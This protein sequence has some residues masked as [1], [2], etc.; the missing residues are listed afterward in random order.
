MLET[1]YVP[2]VLT[3]RSCR[4][5]RDADLRAL[6][7]GG[8]GDVPLVQ[9]RWRCQHCGSRLIGMVVSGYQPAS[10]YWRRD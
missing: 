6:V 9:L 3:C 1:R 10:G 8:R 5:S 2:I 7:D 4:R